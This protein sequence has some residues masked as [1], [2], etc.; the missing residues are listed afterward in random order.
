MYPCGIFSFQQFL[1]STYDVLKLLLLPCAGEMGMNRG[2]ASLSQHR[3]MASTLSDHPLALEMHSLLLSQSLPT[4]SLP[5]LSPQPPAA[6]LSSRASATTRRPAVH[7]CLV[8][9]CYFHSIALHLWWQLGPG[10][11]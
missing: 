1:A 3:P 8:S 7:S 4:D 10:V 9:L 2:L 5:K 6:I 11:P